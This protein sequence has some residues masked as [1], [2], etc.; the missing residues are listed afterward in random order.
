M[1][2]LAAPRPQ[3]RG[4]LDPG[5]R[6]VSAHRAHRWLALLPAL[7]ILVGAPLID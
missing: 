3:R 2:G 4:A 1:V 7:A 5:T 6:A